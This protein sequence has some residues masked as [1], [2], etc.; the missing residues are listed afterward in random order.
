[1]S[2]VRTAE[3]N[4][5][6]GQSVRAAAERRNSELSALKDSHRRVIAALVKASIICAERADQGDTLAQHLLSE[7][8]AAWDGLT[9]ENIAAADL[10]SLVREQLLE[11]EPRGI[12]GA[13]PDADPA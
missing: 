11:E 12:A 8:T 13:E 9:A 6:I 5:K 10:T 7:L 3:H 2:E 4:A 1:M